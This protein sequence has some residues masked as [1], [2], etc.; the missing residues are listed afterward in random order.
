MFVVQKC[1]GGQKCL[2]QKIEF[3]KKSSHL[4]HKSIWGVKNMEKVRNGSKINIFLKKFR[5]FNAFLKY[6]Q[7]W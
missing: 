4:I 1:L 3:K 7:F 2:G 6:F 5:I